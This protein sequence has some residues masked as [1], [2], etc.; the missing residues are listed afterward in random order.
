MGARSGEWQ[1]IGYGSDPVPGDPYEVGRE[2]RDYGDTAATI[3][4]Q[5]YRLRHMAESDDDLKG[6]FVAEL[7]GGMIDVADQLD[8]VY[9]RFLVTSEQLALLEPA[10]EDARDETKKA[11]DMAIEEEGSKSDDD[12]PASPFEQSPAEKKAATAMDTFNGIADGIAQKIKEASDDDM[13]DG[14]WDKVKNAVD[15]I[16]PFLKALKI[17][18]TIAVIVLAVVA[19]FVP[20][21]N[22]IVLGLLIGSLAISLTLAATG[23]GSWTD[24][25]LDVAS[26][27]T[28]GLG[29]AIGALAKGGRSVFLVRQGAT[30]GR[31]AFNS[32]SG[33]SR[34][35]GAYRAFKDVAGRTPFVLP[36]GQAGSLKEI[37]K[38]GFNRDLVGHMRDI[39]QIQKAFPKYNPSRGLL[40]AWTM[41]NGSGLALT[42]N[43]LAGLPGAV[44]AVND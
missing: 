8:K 7:K 18:I 5:A 43:S 17:L 44:G 6:N 22:M 11:L 21:L 25:I 24:V 32:S 40:N 26:L 27:A 36:K 10:L 33:L 41:A 19:L 2:A 20:G 15:A 23:N 37:L 9:N 34:F 3:R 31:A 16:A 29:S 38:S 39:A 42:I 12:E 4:A 14:F 30:S 1:L 28:F 35:S 13:K